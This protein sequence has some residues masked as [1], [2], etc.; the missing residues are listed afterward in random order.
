M[1]DPCGPDEG[2]QRVVAIYAKYVINGANCT[3]KEDT[4]SKTLEGYLKAVNFLF[5]KR[6]FFPP[7]DFNDPQN[8]AARVLKNLEAEEDIAKRRNPVTTEMYAEMVRQGK[9][10]SAG[11]EK[12]LLARL[13]SLAKVVGPRACEY[14]QKTQQK[15]EVH[16]Y[17]S[18]RKEVVK[19]WTRLDFAFRGVRGAHLNPANS[20]NKGRIDKVV[21]TWRVQKNRQN[22]QKITVVRDRD[23]PDLCPVL[24][25]LDIFE[26]SKRIGTK[27][28]E[29]MF[30][31]SD[32][33]GQR[34]YWT[35][36]KVA[37]ALQQVAKKAH[38]DMPKEEVKKYT[39]HSFRVW[40]CVLL[41]EAG[42]SPDFIKDR[43]RWMGDSYRTYLRDTAVINQQHND[44]LAP[45]SKAV[46]S[47]L[48]GN[49]SDA[50]RPD[51]VTADEAMGDYED[52]I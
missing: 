1:P 22:G 32:A 23:H 28:D 33:K 12:W 9:D 13:A 7:A 36:G 21:I 29:P 27:D 11:S 52:I 2:Y 3:N 46:V 37:A 14:V 35:A 18:G 50:L 20:R 30:A 40:A 47:L 6:G 10:A 25:A 38:P 16:R 19:A 15:V 34:R 43:L 24:A 26:H 5:E 42:K 41:S 49:D 17:P 51:N 44:A 31:L 45:A 39:C 48:A 8:L 4:R